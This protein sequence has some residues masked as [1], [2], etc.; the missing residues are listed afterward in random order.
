MNETHGFWKNNNKNNNFLPTYLPNF[1]FR[2]LQ[3]TNNFL[4]LIMPYH[5]GLEIKLFSREPNCIFK[6]LP[7]VFC[8]ENSTFLSSLQKSEGAAGEFKGGLGSWHPLISSPVIPVWPLI[9]FEGDPE[10]SI[11]SRIFAHF[12]DYLANIHCFSL[13]TYDKNIRPRKKNC[14][15]P[16]TVQEKIGLVIR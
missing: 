3:E 14:L 15:F 1:L 6:S 11:G 10:V 5:T 7:N 2:P 9:I 4:G 12:Q 16:V 13:S 8:I